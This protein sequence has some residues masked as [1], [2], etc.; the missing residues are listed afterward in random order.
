MSKL[1]EARKKINVIDKQMAELF[2]AR[3]KASEEVAEYK[4][5]Q[6]LPLED[7]KRESEVIEKNSAYIK[8]PVIREYYVEYQKELMNISK[9]YQAKLLNRDK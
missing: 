1:D 6:N 3:M 9:K 8:D 7:L 5:E 4:K 2:E